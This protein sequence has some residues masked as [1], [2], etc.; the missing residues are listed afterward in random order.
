MIEQKD[1]GQK[2]VFMGLV[3]GLII[4]LSLGWAVFYQLG[5]SQG[6]TDGITI[7]Y[8]VGLESGYTQGLVNGTN[9]GY[10]TGYAL[11]YSKGVIDGVGRGYNIRDPTYAEAMKFVADN[12]VDKNIYLTRFYTCQN[13]ASDFKND[14]FK[15]G[16]KCGYVI[17][18]FPNCSHA[19]V[20][21]NTTDRKMVYIEPQDDS[22]VTVYVCKHYWDRTK[23][24]SPSYD[25]TIEW[26][27]VVW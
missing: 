26:Y 14:A 10:Q 4:G 8:N 12:Q 23:Y 9:A 5:C 20:C 13:F 24:Q 18:D 7:G 27:R 22:I 2:K 3:I 17:I 19:I 21:F 6:K 16:Y 15:A 1:N 25:D 11:G